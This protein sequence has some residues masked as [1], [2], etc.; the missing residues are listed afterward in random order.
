MDE[1]NNIGFHEDCPSFLCVPAEIIEC[2]LRCET[3]LFTDLLSFSE[4]C[5]KFRD[6]VRSN[7]VWR[8]KYFQRW[9]NLLFRYD[10][11]NSNNWL[12]EFKRRHV[13]GRKVILMVSDL[14]SKLYL[15][16]KGILS[17][18]D[19]KDFTQLMASNHRYAEFIVDELMS[20]LNDTE[21]EKK[22][23]TKYYAQ[24]VLIAAQE[25][26]LTDKVKLYTQLPQEKQLIE[27]GAILL[28]QWCQP[29]ESIVMNEITN[30]ID[31][32]AEA[33][34]K[35]IMST[36]PQHP[37]LNSPLHT[38]YF[39]EDLWSCEQS[40]QILLALNK[41][42]FK[43][44]K[45][46]GAKDGDR[47]YDP[48]NSYIDK[49]LSR[50]TGIPITLCILYSAVARRL[51]VICEPV[52]SPYHFVLRWKEHPMS[53]SQEHMYTY[54]DVFNGG[55]FVSID[56]LPTSIHVLR[57]Y[58]T[59]DSL[60]AI[61]AIGVLCRMVRNLINIVQHQRA[62]GNNYSNTQCLRSA[63]EFIVLIAPQEVEFKLYLVR[64]YI[65]MNI[66]LLDCISILQ[67]MMGE[68]NQDQGNIVP[69]LLT[70]AEAQHH[71]NMEQNAEKKIKAKT[72]SKPSDAIFS[73]G[74]VMRHKR[75][76][77]DCVIFG[78]DPKCMATPDWILQMGVHNLPN[79]DKQ[80]FYNVLVS[81]GSN[82]YAAQENL[83]LNS[84]CC[85]ITHPEVGKYFTSF[86]GTHYK[87]NNENATE[88][89]EDEEITLRLVHEHYHV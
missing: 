12:D 9:P 1:D 31:R 19:L 32:L 14:S 89:P 40:K 83:E 26:I 75:Y 21:R 68:D 49:V 65:N 72:R 73:V 27:T 10:T 5:L 43:D 70:S 51:G 67:S 39:M 76:N 53:A 71:R 36:L 25:T 18:D 6:A 13:V 58:L 64:L 15:Q 7:N 8:E 79:K 86:E 20:L 57:H 77:Y 82:R 81:D 34:K 48:L 22:L 4:V 87:Q 74:L 11:G 56:E 55:K 54:I 52:N 62:P 28:A 50:K 69:Y 47:Y 46:H 16:D 38:E 29:I 88:Y 33:V 23:T 80:P 3:L 85:M 44:K 42:L 30:E 41:V 17:K 37:V 35:D 2:I 45:F 60:R 63:L 66:N 78:W 84:N 59:A 61:N 24:K